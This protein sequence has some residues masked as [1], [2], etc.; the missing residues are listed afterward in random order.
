MLARLP[1]VLPRLS[2][3]ERSELGSVVNDSAVRCQSRTLTEPQR[4]EGDRRSRWI[5]LIKEAMLAEHLYQN[6]SCPIRRLR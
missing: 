5:G 3:N 6:L 1:K 2:E 4:E